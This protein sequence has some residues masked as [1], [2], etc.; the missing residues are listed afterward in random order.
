MWALAQLSGWCNTSCKTPRCTAATECM[1]QNKLCLA[2]QCFCPCLSWQQ[3]HL[4]CWK[5]S[6]LESFQDIGKQVVGASAYKA[7]VFDLMQCSERLFKAACFLQN[8][9]KVLDHLMELVSHPPDP[10]MEALSAQGCTGRIMSKY[11]N[12]SSCSPSSA[13]LLLC[14]SAEAQVCPMCARWACCLA[15]LYLYT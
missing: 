7:V 8:D 10:A 3:P 5:I 9:E 14:I 15:E 1:W 13:S 11:R 4:Q 6:K 2:T 12:P